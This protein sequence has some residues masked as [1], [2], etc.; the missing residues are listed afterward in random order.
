MARLLT[1]G[2]EVGS[3]ATFTL[4]PEDPGFTQA[5]NTGTYTLS[6]DSTLAHG[7]GSSVKYTSTSASANAQAQ[8]AWPFTGNASLTYFARLAVYAQTAQLGSLASFPAL[9]IQT[10]GGLGAYAVIT[11]ANQVQVQNQAGAVQVN[12]P[13][14]S[15][16]VWVVVEISLTPQTGFCGLVVGGSNYG[17]GA[18]DAFS[19]SAMQIVFGWENTNNA[20]A[21]TWNYDELALN[22]STG[23]AQNTFCG[24]NKIALLRPVS[25]SRNT[26]F[27][28]DG[29]QATVG[30]FAAVDNA[31]PVGVAQ[32]A[33]SATSQIEDN[34]ANTTDNYQASM[35]AYTTA[36]ASGGG[37]VGTLDTVALVQGICSHG[38][39]SS[40]GQYTDGLRVASNPV[41]A[42]TTGLTPAAQ[43]GTYPAGWVTL[44]TGP[45]YNPPVTLGTGPVVAFRKGSVTT[46]YVMA[47]M[48][49]LYVESIPFT[50][51]TSIS[52]ADATATS[53]LVVKRATILTS[54]IEY[55]LSGGAQNLAIDL[56]LGGPIAN[57][58]IPANAFNNVWDGITATQAA[59]GITTYACVYLKNNTGGT[60]A[61]QS[62]VVWIDG[63]PAQGTAAI[64][65]DS[66]PMG[67][68]AVSS[69]PLTTV[70][71]T[72]AITFS[73][74]TSQGAGISLGTNMPPGSYKAIWLRRTIPPGAVNNSSDSISIQVAG[75][76]F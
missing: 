25:D 34:T 23:S 3:P 54:E 40:T 51:T 62:V 6:I 12:G 16:G 5:T 75:T 20:S 64:G 14:I 21:N 26:G 65:I 43:A 28:T 10:P 1:C 22:D 29:A 60:F 24:A 59:S 36:L 27:T 42:E 63:V 9:S 55:H 72:P 7:G 48:I 66:A 38:S 39:T 11:S 4:A 50:P 17:T 2:F 71:P 61:F 52:V 18:A 74:P 76:S 45:V 68:T 57:G 33:G 19:T 15:T 58:T 30:L 73:S 70:A 37:G 13:T 53:E 47:C 31:P 67:Q 69:S 56:S 32:G 44:K 35:G 41:I 8:F 49:G 46:D